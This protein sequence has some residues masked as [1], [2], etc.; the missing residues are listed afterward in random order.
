M[1]TIE[2]KENETIIKE[3]ETG[4]HFYIIQK[5]SVLVTQKGS[6]LNKKL[7][8]GQYFGERALIENEPR[9]A[10][11]TCAS[12]KCVCVVLDKANFMRLLDDLFANMIQWMKN[13]TLP[14][15]GN[16]SDISEVDID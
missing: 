9:S 4:E 11:V 13:Y 8:K 2:Y 16:D 12:A 3:G 14:K 10:T 6:T 15:D 1:E 5:G 7:T